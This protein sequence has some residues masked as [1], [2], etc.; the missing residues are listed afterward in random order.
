MSQIKLG[1]DCRFSYMY[2]F[3]VNDD[4]NYQT[5]IL[6]PKSDQN[7]TAIL[8][9]AVGQLYQQAQGDQKFQAAIG[10][11]SFRWQCIHDGDVKKFGK[12]DQATYAGHWYITAKTKERPPVV[13]MSGRFLT[14]DAEF[15]SGCYG[16]VGVEPRLYSPSEKAPK[17]GYGIR[18]RL[19]G[20]CKVRGTEADR[21]A[22][23]AA[24]E[25]SGFFGVQAQPQPPM[26]GM[27]PYPAQSPYGA[28]GPGGAPTP[29]QFQ[30]GPNQQQYGQPQPAPQPY[31][32]PTPQGMPQSPGQYP[33]PGQF[34]QPQQ[35]FAPTQPQAPANPYGNPGAPVQ[36][37]NPG[38]A[39]PMAQPVPGQAQ[40]YPQPQANPFPQVAPA[41][42]QMPAQQFGAPS[43][44]YQAPQQPVPQPGP[45]QPTPAFDPYGQP[46]APGGLPY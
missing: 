23:N 6:W 11:Q 1:P 19:L 17:S 5:D 46:G 32:Q 16:Y 10:Q 20:F 7:T 25:V 18:F 26:P 40:G 33:Q 41:A 8:Q 22:G 3:Q 45:H 31:A 13:D 24:I 27:S 29:P 42:P 34:G 43:P 35:G 2:C 12:K 44:Q 9:N 15:F 30:P 38:Y 36:P 39:P 4:G 37:V 21:L 14:T 28:S